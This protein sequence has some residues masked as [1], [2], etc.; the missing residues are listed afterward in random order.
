MTDHDDALAALWH[1]FADMNRR[2]VVMNARRSGKSWLMQEMMEYESPRQP[3]PPKYL[4]PVNDRDPAFLE[5]REEGCRQSCERCG[6]PSLWSRVG[7]ALVCTSEPCRVE[8]CRSAAQPTT[9][10]LGDLAELLCPDA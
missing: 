9:S 5:P 4:P 8:H 7:G 3:E 1:L 10:N 6:E 2:Q